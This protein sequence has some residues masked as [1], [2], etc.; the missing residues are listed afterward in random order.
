VLYPCSNTDHVTVSGSAPP[1]QNYAL[2][3]DSQSEPLTFTHD[4]FA[5]A[6]EGSDAD[7]S[8]CGGLTYAATL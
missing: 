8:L 5:I 4:A 2:F 6:L 7:S 1:T 3:T